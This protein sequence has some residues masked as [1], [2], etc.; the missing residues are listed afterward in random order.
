[1]LSILSPAKTMKFDYQNDALSPTLPVFEKE[2]KVLVKELRK[3]SVPQLMELM[4]ISEKLA[5]LNTDRFNNF[6]GSSQTEEAVQAL[7]A[8]RG[9]VYQGLEAMELSDSSLKN[10]N[11]HLRILTG[12]YGILRPSDLIEPYRLEM[13]IP[14]KV[15][16]TKDLYEFWGDKVT[17]ELEKAM[18]ETNSKYLVNLASKEYSNVVDKGAFKDRWIEIEFKELRNGKLKFIT[19]NA[20]KARGQMA[21]FIIENDSEK[22]S[23]L[24][25]FSGGGYLYDE[26]GSTPG[27][28]LFVKPE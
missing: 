27:K 13:G 28:L 12:L 3:L 7:F 4:S 11:A 23:D 6:K 1:M 8:Y 2:S 26:K 25:S 17:R 18:K 9:D 21:R 5:K 22:V 15:G 20:K 10:A 14:L 16:K 24:Y 19:F